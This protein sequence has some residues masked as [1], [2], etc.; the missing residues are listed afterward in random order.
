M[1]QL[2]NEEE[3]AGFFRNGFVIIRNALPHS[4]VEELRGECTG[5]VAAVREEHGPQV[6]RF[7]PISRYTELLD[8]KPFE[9][10]AT[11]PELQ[12]A[13]EAIL[14]PDVFYGRLED[15]GVF[16]EPAERP[17]VQPWHRDMWLDQS[18][19]PPEAYERFALDWD[20]L[21]QINCALY[22]DTC[23]WYVPGSHLR[24]SNSD[25]EQS[26]VSLPEDL[27]GDVTEEQLLGYVREMP[28][29]T[30]VH[31]QAGDLLLYR[32]IGWHCGCYSPTRQRATMLDVLY[33]P[34]YFAWRHPWLSGESPAWKPE[35]AT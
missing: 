1:K 17:W 14:G 34:A 3:I 4:L 2:V 32:A 33:S 27:S 35:I 16:I 28:G 15:A 19:L 29:A 11:L 20:S 5:A 13:F 6:Q 21:N 25:A 22:D 9:A 30:Q 23:T 12:Q 7:Q 10:Y 31:L 26:L 18:R 24:V 8:I